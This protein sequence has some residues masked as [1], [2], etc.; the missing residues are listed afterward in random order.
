MIIID[1]VID[2]F[3]T[4]VFFIPREIR[5]WYVDKMHAYTNVQMNQKGQE[6]CW[7]CMILLFLAGLPGTVIC[8]FIT[9]K[10]N[11]RKKRHALRLSAG[12]MIIFIIWGCVEPG[13]FIP[14]NLPVNDIFERLFISLNPIRLAFACFYCQF[15]IQTEEFRLMKPDEMAIREEE[16]TEDLDTYVEKGEE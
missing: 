2:L 4:L 9:N 7:I 15:S 6:L 16:E 13:F 8:S 10:S 1:F 14:Y 3:W 12:L 11:D 5:S